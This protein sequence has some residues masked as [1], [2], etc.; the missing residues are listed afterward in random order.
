MILSIGKEKLFVLLVW[1]VNILIH[2]IQNVYLK[3][4]PYH[5]ILTNPLKQQCFIITKQLEILSQ[6]KVYHQF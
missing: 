3:T 5:L 4:L 2:P 6:M 1:L